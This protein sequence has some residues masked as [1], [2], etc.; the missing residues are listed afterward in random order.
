MLVRTDRQVADGLRR[1]VRPI[2]V[3]LE[4]WRVGGIEVLPMLG[5]PVFASCAVQSAPQLR[6]LQPLSTA[7]RHSHHRSRWTIAALG[8]C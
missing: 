2:P 6:V 1:D 4:D 7:G 8:G 3:I 5:F